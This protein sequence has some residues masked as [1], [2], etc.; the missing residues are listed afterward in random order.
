MSPTA[1]GSGNHRRPEERP[2]RSVILLFAFDLMSLRQISIE[3]GM[4]YLSLGA[5]KEYRRHNG[6]FPERIVVYRDGVGDGQLHSV[7]NY[8][9]KQIIDS[10]TSM[11][12]D[13]S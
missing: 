5:L 7:V 9:V 10:M 3:V 2:E 13:Y 1:Q 12:A 11:Q 8:E 6:C 4:S